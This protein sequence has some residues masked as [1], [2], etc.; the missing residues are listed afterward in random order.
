MREESNHIERGFRFVA[1]YLKQLEC[2]LGIEKS[3]AQK[4]LQTGDK[5]N[6]DLHQHS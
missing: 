1:E 5:V 2:G 6:D 3:K 4:A